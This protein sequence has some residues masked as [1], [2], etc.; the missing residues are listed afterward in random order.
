MALAVAGWSTPIRFGG[1]TT[2]APIRPDLFDRTR[3]LVVAGVLIALALAP[4]L[5]MGPGTDLD[6]GAV[7]HSGQSIVDHFH[8]I[9]SRAPGAPVQEATV[10]VLYK[11]A[12]TVG[13]N[14]GSLVAAAVCLVAW[15]CCCADAASVAPGWWWRW[16]S[17]THGSWWRRRQPSTSFGPW[18]S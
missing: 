10:G 16:S 18:R 17:P 12:G 1:L 4:F 15:C 2:G 11:L 8:Y 6:A 7:I 3:N 5:F 14:L 13:A 9:P